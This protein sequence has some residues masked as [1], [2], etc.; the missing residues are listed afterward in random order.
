MKTLKELKERAWFRLLKVLYLAL[1]MPYVIILAIGVSDY[2]RE[3]HPE[4]LPLSFLD[5]V[6]DPKF[7]SLDSEKKI[8]VLSRIDSEFAD[9]TLEEQKK[10]IKDIESNN[11]DISGTKSKTY[12]VTD[13]STNKT[14]TFEWKELNLPTKEDL[15]EIFATAKRM[16]RQGKLSKEK[17]ALLAEAR[18]RGLAPLPSN[19]DS[20]ELVVVGDKSA[21]DVA[22]IK[23]NI[24][25]MMDQKAPQ[26]DI[27][28]YMASEGVTLLKQEDIIWDE[29]QYTYNYSSY[30]TWKIKEAF[31][32]A[33]IFSLA[34]FVVMEAIKRAFY[35]VVIGKV[36]PKE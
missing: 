13:P 8:A 23:R 4:E 29:K 17:K 20:W 21:A 7:K 33:I 32:F 5:A 22:K 1:Y 12:T 31:Y 35:Y 19:I 25:K 24:R 10:G 28:A 26:E 27:N 30:Y 18:S 14:I 11:I 15:D 9:L 34:Y 3:Y 6:K 16:E 36:F 2:G